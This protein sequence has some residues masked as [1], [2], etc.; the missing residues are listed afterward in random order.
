LGGLKMKKKK[1]EEITGIKF[2]DNKNR[3]DLL[4]LDAIE[5]IGKVM[6][7]G[8]VVKEYG[9]RNWENGFKWSRLLGALFRHIFAFWR[10]ENYDPESKLPHL[11]HAGCC[12]LFLLAHFLRKI[13]EDDRVEKES[14]AYHNQI[15]EKK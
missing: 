14:I 12:I 1:E 15:N 8:A 4:P 5:E 11:A 9:D 10:G 2:D 13:G 3:L 6:T 7:F